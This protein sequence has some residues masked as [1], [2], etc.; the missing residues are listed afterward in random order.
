ME[1]KSLFD[2]HYNDIVR[3]A[4]STRWIHAHFGDVGLV[5]AVFARGQL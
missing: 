3:F 1:L 5:D 2:C 4:L